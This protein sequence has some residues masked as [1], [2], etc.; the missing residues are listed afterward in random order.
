[1]FPKMAS[2]RR[3]LQQQLCGGRGGRGTVDGHASYFSLHVEKVHWRE[4]QN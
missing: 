3:K 1:M 4:E 2:S